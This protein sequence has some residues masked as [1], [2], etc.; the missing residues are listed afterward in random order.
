MV[1]HQSWRRGHERSV[2]ILLFF[3]VG[4]GWRHGAAFK[5]ASAT[6]SGL[7][8]CFCRDCSFCGGGAVPYF[9]DVAAYSTF[10]ALC[11]PLRIAK[12]RHPCASM[13]WVASLFHIPRAL[14]LKIQWQRHQESSSHLCLFHPSYLPTTISSNARSSVSRCSLPPHS[15][16]RLP[17]AQTCQGVQFPL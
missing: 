10:V 8:I 3:A 16:W 1:H 5:C 7:I 9:K 14:R 13:A 15:S 6:V 11:T 12:R 17:Y 4:S 2:F